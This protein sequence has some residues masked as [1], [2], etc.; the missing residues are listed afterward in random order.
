LTRLGLPVTIHFGVAKVGD[1]LDGHSWVTVEGQP[2]A[3]RLP[4]EHWQIVYA[5]PS[6]T[7]CPARDAPVSATSR[8]VRMIRSLR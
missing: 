7:A 1:A 2:V 6:A 8:Y 4:L 3:E 5:Y